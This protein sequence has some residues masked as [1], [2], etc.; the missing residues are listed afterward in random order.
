MQI[1]TN[2]RLC[3]VSQ[4]EFTA[5]RERHSEARMESI[6]KSHN[7]RGTAST[8][9]TTNGAQGWLVRRFK[10]STERRGGSLSTRWPGSW[11]GERRCSII[12]RDNWAIVTPDWPTAAASTTVRLQLIP[13]SSRPAS[14]ARSRSL[15]AAAW[16]GDVAAVLAPAVVSPRL[17]AA[18]WRKSSRLYYVP[19]GRRRRSELFELGV[20]K[21]AAQPTAAR[22]LT[23]A[24]PP[25][26]I[27]LRPRRGLN[28]AGA[29]VRWIRSVIPSDISQLA[30]RHQHHSASVW[31]SCTDGLLR[32]RQD[33]VDRCLRRCRHFPRSHTLRLPFNPNYSHL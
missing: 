6:L 20:N 33:Y 28:Y 10:C 8:G 9:T 30:G 22:R 14:E 7:P 23:T 21:W 18:G 2:L 25:C 29:A 3:T 26:T 16:N 31:S 19:T 27:T 17:C 24:R 15:L 12:D 4:L 1:Y 32:H 11:A 13:D 5:T